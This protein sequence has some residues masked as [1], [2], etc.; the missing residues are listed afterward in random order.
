[1]TKVFGID[2]RLDLPILFVDDDFL[3]YLEEED[4]YDNINI[5]DFEK[6]FVKWMKENCE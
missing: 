6:Y 1:V 5:F 2:V 3:E 4:V